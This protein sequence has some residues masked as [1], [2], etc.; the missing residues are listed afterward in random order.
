MPFKIGDAVKR[1]KGWAY[2]EEE[3]IVSEILPEAGQVIVTKGEVLAKY[4][5][6]NIKK[7]DDK[8]INPENP[9]TKKP[10]FLKKIFGSRKIIFGSKLP[11]VHY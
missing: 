1:I 3:W 11:I 4:Q 9:K 10:G 6:E 2:T 8:K 5:F 7:I